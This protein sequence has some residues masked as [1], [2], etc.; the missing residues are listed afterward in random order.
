MTVARSSVVQNSR[1]FKQNCS[2]SHK[3]P[4]NS[5]SYVFL[6]QVWFNL[7]RGRLELA[8]G[9]ALNWRYGWLEAGVE[10]PVV[11]NAASGSPH[12]CCILTPAKAVRNIHTK[13]AA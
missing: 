12:A 9:L 6:V 13:L 11:N 8:Q 2:Q 10:I 5:F 4:F 3:A 1:Y 7:A